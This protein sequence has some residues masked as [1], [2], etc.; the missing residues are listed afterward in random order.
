MKKILV[1]GLALISHPV[2][3]AETSVLEASK[4]RDFAR[5][6]PE[7]GVSQLHYQETGVP[8]HHQTS[9]YGRMQFVGGVAQTPLYFE[10][11]L[12]GSLASLSRNQTQNA[13]TWGFDALM[14]IDATSPHTDWLAHFGLGYGH[15][16]M[17]VTD[18]AFGYNNLNGPVLQA[19]VGYRTSTGQRFWIGHKSL[20]SLSVSSTYSMINS[21]TYDFSN[22]TA[23]APFVSLSW[24]TT[25][26]TLV[27]TEAG[28]AGRF[29]VRENSLALSLGHSI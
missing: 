28:N 16:S 5:L 2:L 19:R 13:R 9:L 1:V 23:A 4:H 29:S 15:R 8:N 14:N 27:S 11:N 10:S 24:Q 18:S 7:L 26:I 12:F 22:P 21:L 6:N 3:A 17:R 20:F 25:G